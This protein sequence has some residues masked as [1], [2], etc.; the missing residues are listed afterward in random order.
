VSF[1]F[2]IVGN[3]KVQQVDNNKWSYQ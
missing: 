1:P 2:P 3:K